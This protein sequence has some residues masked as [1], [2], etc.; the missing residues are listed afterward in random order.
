MTTYKAYVCE[1]RF[2]YDDCC[3]S[4]A[5]RITGFFEPVAHHGVPTVLFECPGALQLDVKCVILGE[6]R[7]R[8]TMTRHETR[9]IGARMEVCGV[10]A[11]S[12]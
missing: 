5:H 1:P 12:A 3:F 8:P 9:K 7:G 4:C 6:T 2:H 10:D 11:V